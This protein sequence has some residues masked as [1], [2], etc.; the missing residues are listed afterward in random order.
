[1]NIIV[2]HSSKPGPIPATNSLPIDTLAIQPY[3]IRPIPGGISGVI[4]E[5]AAVTTV[6]KDLLIPF[7]SISGTSIFASIAASASAD[8]DS[9]PISV[10]SRIL[11]WLRPPYMRPV[12]TEQKSMMR[13]VTPV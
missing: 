10:E 5:D 13:L 2:M 1:M 6:E 11:T 4:I 7:F 8:P 9:P 12:S 3:R